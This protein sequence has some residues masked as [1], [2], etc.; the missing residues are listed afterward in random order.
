V[1]MRE[2]LHMCLVACIAYILTWKVDAQKIHTT[3]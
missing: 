3:V 1:R 2:I